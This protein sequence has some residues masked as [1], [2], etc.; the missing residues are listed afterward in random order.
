[1]FFYS[2]ELKTF[3]SISYFLFL[4]KLFSCYHGYHFAYLVLFQFIFYEI[5]KNPDDEKKKKNWKLAQ[6]T[7]KKDVS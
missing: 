6:I 3:Y 2:W 4:V 1:M 5:K 7:Y